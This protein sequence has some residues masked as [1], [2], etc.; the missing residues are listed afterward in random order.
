MEENSGN[1]IKQNCDTLHYS[2]WAWEGY[3]QEDKFSRYN[4]LVDE[5]ETEK[6]SVY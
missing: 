2:W 1:Y 6:N 5:V 3:Y 4:K